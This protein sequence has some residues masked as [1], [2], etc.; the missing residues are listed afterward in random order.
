MKTQGEVLRRI[1][2]LL[3]FEW[4]RRCSLELAVIPDS[5]RHH[6]WH[7]ID[8]RKE[9]NG[10]PNPQYNQVTAS[11]GKQIGL[12]LY[13]SSN[14]DWPGDLCEDTVDALRCKKYSAKHTPEKAYAKLIVCLKDEEWVASNLP[15]VQAL[16]WVLEPTGVSLDNRSWWEKIL[17]RWLGYHPPVVE[18]SDRVMDLF[19]LL[20]PL[21]DLPSFIHVADPA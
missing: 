3:T 10:H 9:I 19:L 8:V 2:D 7:G 18:A 21:E 16:Y 14:G 5:C 15:E 1:Q 11:G 13:G 6:H 4:T 20:P 12:C 17:H